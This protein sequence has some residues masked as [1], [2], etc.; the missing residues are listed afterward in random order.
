MWA[1]L[2]LSLALLLWSWGRKR[3]SKKLLPPTTVAS[4]T[5]HTSDFQVKLQ[6]AATKAT[7][8]G[9]IVDGVTNT[10]RTVVDGFVYPCVKSYAP[11]I[12]Y[13]RLTG[14]TTFI[15][16]PNGEY[17]AGTIACLKD[18]ELYMPTAALVD[19]IQ[20]EHCTYNT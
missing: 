8:T 3:P 20:A 15:P 12:G 16:A 2:V 1:I 4:S 7:R 6:P 17:I 18:S 14:Y 5:T 10:A 11:L 19:S 9:T 13:S